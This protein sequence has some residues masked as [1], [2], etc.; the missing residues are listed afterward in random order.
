M[1]KFLKS[2]FGLN[3]MTILFFLINAIYFVRIKAEGPAIFC[4]AVVIVFS[5]LLPLCSKNN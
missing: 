2:A 1:K 5:A 3:L 4:S